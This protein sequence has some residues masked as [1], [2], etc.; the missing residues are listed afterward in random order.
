[1]QRD[2]LQ[3]LNSLKFSFYLK[4]ILHFVYKRN[5]LL[6][7]KLGGDDVIDL[8]AWVVGTTFSLAD[9][10]LGSVL[11]SWP[12]LSLLI[13]GWLSLSLEVNVVNVWLKASESFGSSNN[14]SGRVLDGNNELSASGLVG[15]LKVGLEVNS[16]SSVNW[17][18]GGIEVGEV[19]GSVR[20]SV[21]NGEQLASIEWVEVDLAQDL[22][23]SIDSDNVAQQAADL[24][25]SWVWQQTA[26]GSATSDNTSV[27]NNL[28][29]VVD[30]LFDEGNAGR[31]QVKLQ[32]RV[33]LKVLN[34]GLEAVQLGE[35]QVGF[36]DVAWVVS[37][38]KLN[39]N[40]LHQILWWSLDSKS[41]HS[42]DSQDS[43]KGKQSGSKHLSFFFLYSSFVG[44][45]VY[46][47][48]ED[49]LSVHVSHGC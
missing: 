9:S 15:D 14:V 21:A 22:N 16:S 42:Q 34:L 33:G 26:Q 24:S 37:F 6:D 3:E 48:Y 25:N 13:L 45:K 40:L 29:E 18:W 5:L 28:D 35:L 32:V 47:V 30:G 27:G 46:T 10:K 31:A 19:G 41:W 1:M 43:H 39:G 38:S 2:E 44:D 12:L 11:T 20:G 7:I 49:V 8:R 4:Q 36:E 23:E 17:V